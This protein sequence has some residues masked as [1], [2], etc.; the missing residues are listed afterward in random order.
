M[1][2]FI[3]AVGWCTAGAPPLWPHLCSAL[4]GQLWGSASE[5]NGEDNGAALGS[6]QPHGNTTGLGSSGWK[7][8]P[9]KRTWGCWSVEMQE[10]DLALATISSEWFLPQCLDV[11]PCICW[12]SHRPSLPC[13]YYGI[14]KQGR[15]PEPVFLNALL[16]IQGCHH[17][18]PLPWGKSTL[19]SP[20]PSTGKTALYLKF[21]AEITL[22]EADSIERVQWMEHALHHPCVFSISEWR[23][24]VGTGNTGPA[25]V[26]FLKFLCNCLPWTKAW[27]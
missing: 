13:C 15:F 12:L 5:I 6:Q 17:I 7:A 14:K 25:A 27:D 3:T 19:L 23:L 9:R 20:L 4:V 10:S 8:A 16:Q 18:P 26:M 1:S 24:L 22:L 21:P 2:G 11:V